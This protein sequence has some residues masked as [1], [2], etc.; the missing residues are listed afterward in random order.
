M[1]RLI[2]K[3]DD[4]GMHILFNGIEE[5]VDHKDEILDI[6]YGPS[7]NIEWKFDKPL[8]NPEWM[9]RSSFKKNSKKR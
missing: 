8:D 1:K 7:Y 6:T 4:Y 3:S 5:Q 2:K 9:L